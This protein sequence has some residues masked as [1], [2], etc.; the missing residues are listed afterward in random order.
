MAH[1]RALPCK[2]DLLTIGKPQAQAKKLRLESKAL[3]ARLSDEELNWL[4]FLV[5]NLRSL[6]PFRHQ[7]EDILSGAGWQAAPGED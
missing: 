6:A 2:P 1:R 5:G 7:I 4:M 3:T